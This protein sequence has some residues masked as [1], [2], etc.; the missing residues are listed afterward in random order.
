[1][2]STIYCKFCETQLSK[3]NERELIVKFHTEC[4][5]CDETLDLWECQSSVL[6]RY[7]KYEDADNCKYE[8]W[9]HASTLPDWLRNWDYK[10]S[11]AVHIGSKESAL[12]RKA[13]L[14]LQ[15]Y[16]LYEVKLKLDTIWHEEILQEDTIFYD[17]IS[18]PKTM[19]ARRPNGWK[20][21]AYR[22]VNKF[23]VPGSISIMTYPENIEI[24][25][26]RKLEVKY[27]RKA[28]VR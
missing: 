18:T 19:Y 25:D 22:Y 12:E 17:R 8:T 27:V 14:Q 2:K 13:Q 21:T 15:T 3:E 9:W 16:Y 10:E 28:S 11:S 24:C 7:Q 5:G 4:P 1:M 23:E 26:V 6:P 20:K